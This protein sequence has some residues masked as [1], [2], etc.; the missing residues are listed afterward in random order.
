VQAGIAAIAM[1]SRSPPPIAILRS[2]F[3]LPS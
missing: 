1:M 2:I 3:M